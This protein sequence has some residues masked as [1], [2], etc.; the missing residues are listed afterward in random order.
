MRVKNRYD[1]IRLQETEP[2]SSMNGW[3][4]V[5]VLHDARLLLGTRILLPRHSAC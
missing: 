3:A 2:I 1:A 4:K 5:G